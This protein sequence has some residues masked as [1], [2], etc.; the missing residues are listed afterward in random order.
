MIDDSAARATFNTKRRV[1]GVASGEGRDVG[2]S[3]RASAEAC[4]DLGGQYIR[5]LDETENPS[6]RGRIVPDAERTLKAVT[7]ATNQKLR[8]TNPAGDDRPGAE[9]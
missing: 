5:G 6:K 4:P 2:S 1:V 9:R 8:G 7:A 3:L